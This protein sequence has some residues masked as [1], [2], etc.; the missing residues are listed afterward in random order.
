[1]HVYIY[2]QY[3][4]P[5]S[6]QSLDSWWLLLHWCSRERSDPPPVRI[7]HMNHVPRDRLYREVFTTRGQNLFHKVIIET[8]KMT[9]N[10]FGQGLK[11]ARYLRSINDHRTAGAV[12]PSLSSCLHESKEPHQHLHNSCAYLGLNHGQPRFFKN[13]KKKKLWKFRW[14]LKRPDC[15]SKKIKS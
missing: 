10:Q 3:I 15:S 7:L 12:A 11:I 14:H 8:T 5:I 13:K 9:W 4:F 6:G 1:M 2:N